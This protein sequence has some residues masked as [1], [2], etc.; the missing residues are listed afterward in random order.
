[1]GAHVQV[2]LQNTPL[3]DFLGF[4]SDAQGALE[5]DED[6]ASGFE[7]ILDALMGGD[8]SDMRAAL[9]LKAELGPLTGE[10]EVEVDMSAI[11][12]ALEKL[13]NALAPVAAA[14]DQLLVPDPKQIADAQNAFAEL[15]RAVN[16]H[17]KRYDAAT[18]LP[19]GMYT[20]QFGALRQAETAQNS[21][22]NLLQLGKLLQ[23]LDTLLGDMGAQNGKAN[24]AN[25]DAQLAALGTDTE[26]SPKENEKLSLNIHEMIKRL[27]GL[28]EKLPET[29]QAAIAKLIDKKSAQ[30]GTD[31]ETDPMAK[32]MASEDAGSKKALQNSSASNLITAALEG[33]EAGQKTEF[34]T[35]RDGAFTQNQLM[36][37]QRYAA[38]RPAPNLAQSAK[39]A[40]ELDVTETVGDKILNIQRTEQLQQT[41]IQLDKVAHQQAPQKQINL[42]AMAF[43]VVRQIRNGAQRF[44]IRLDPPEMGKI[45]V[46]LE[47][48]GKNVTARLTVERAETL[49]FLQ[50][51]QRALERAL[52]Q[53]GLNTDKANLQFS[54]KQDQNGGQGQQFGQEQKQQ[55]A[56]LKGDTDT[57]ASNAQS[58]T[59]N[60]SLVLRGTARPDG[61]N[62]WV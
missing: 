51:D 27:E 56:G 28:S 3:V 50:R 38:Q 5:G 48:E 40:S 47:M 2:G 13:K 42:P 53:A 15:A 31:G 52:Q 25:I 49:D 24:K 44:E 36:A 6:A 55:Q 30:I 39:M 35:N 58:I 37:D 60:P 46:Q 11:K 23:R 41:Q 29:A 45:D 34:G 1:M 19:M 4:A 21:Q 54:L 32:L 26:L 18:S 62:L 43:E 14:F 10:G 59:E 16:N 61:L 9:H 20:D 22:G 7:A 17:P 57:L 12:D 8:A 33:K